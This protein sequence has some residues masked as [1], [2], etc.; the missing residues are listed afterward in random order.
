MPFPDVHI[1]V[2]S[3]GHHHWLPEQV[4]A[5]G[6]IPVAAMAAVTDGLQ[7]FSIGADFLHGGEVSVANPYVVMG[8]DSHAMGLVRVAN[9]ILADG[10]DELMVGPVLIQLRSALNAAL[11][12]PEISPGVESHRWHAAGSGRGCIG[13]RV[14]VPHGLLPFDALRMVIFAL[15]RSDNAIGHAVAAYWRMAAI[16]HTF[17]YGWL[18]PVSP[19]Q[20]G[21]LT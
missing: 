10:A 20:D 9:H 18:L 6:F 2:R 8:I 11:E 13:I 3:E 1:T 21:H 12:S 15:L 17:Y 16:R 4:P 19:W 5:P 7:E 14:G